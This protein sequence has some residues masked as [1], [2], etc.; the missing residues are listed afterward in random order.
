MSKYFAYLA[1]CSDESL[2]S[3]STN[4][5]ARRELVHNEGAGARYTKA[6]LPV[7]IIYFEEFVNRSDAMKREAAF[8]KLSKGQ[9]EKLLTGTA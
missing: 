1:R 2:Y 9:K 6:R 7:K 4:D 3:G 8:K 5:V